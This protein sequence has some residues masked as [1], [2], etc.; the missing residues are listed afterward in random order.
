MKTLIRIFDINYVQIQVF[1]KDKPIEFTKTI[2]NGF[3]SVFFFKKVNEQDIKVQVDYLTK[4]Y[5]RGSITSLEIYKSYI[6]HNTMALIQKKNKDSAFEETEEITVDKIQIPEL[7]EL[8]KETTYYDQLYGYVQNASTTSPQRNLRSD[9]TDEVTYSFD[10]GS[11]NTIA[12]E[13]EVKDRGLPDEYTGLFLTE[14]DYFSPLSLSG[15]TLEIRKF[16]FSQFS[17]APLL[18][19]QMTSLPTVILHN[20]NVLDLSFARSFRDRF[21]IDINPTEINKISIYTLTNQKY[22]L[23][24]DLGIRI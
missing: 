11:V 10:E 9:S 6:L 15:S 2:D 3:L 21:E 13:D 24:L 17:K 4:P 7:D 12:Y 16:G 1:E 18:I 19:H 23:I 14:N 8:I 5:P 22:P 20:M